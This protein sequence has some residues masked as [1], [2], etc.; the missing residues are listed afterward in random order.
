MLIYLF[1]FLFMSLLNLNQANLS[2]IRLIASDVDGTLTQNGKF[3]SDFISTLLDLQSAGIKVLLV[4]GRSAGWVSALV[5]YLPVAG[6]IAENGGVFLQ[7][8]GQQDLLSSIPN[9]SRHRILLENTFHHIKQLFPNLHPSADNQF[10]I[11]DWT[12]DVDNLS[13]EDIQAIS[14][15]CQQMGWSFTYSNVQ[16]HIKPLHQDKATGLMSVL[17]KYFP[18]FNSQQVLTIG[19]SPNDEAMFN[20]DLFPISVG[21]ANVRHYQDEMLHLPKYVTQAS[22]FAG[23]SELA[24]LLLQ[25]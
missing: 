10:R 9:L 1:W 17:K 6:A 14:S 13:T 3:S 4:T 23:F 18:E 16:C 7:P 25:T 22:E 15:Q 20:P 21:V 12:F 24:K 8:D 19:D 11:T 5:N 2:D